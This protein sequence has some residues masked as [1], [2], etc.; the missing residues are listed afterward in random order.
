MNYFTRKDYMADPCHAV[1][2]EADRAAAHRRYYAQFVTP[3][4]LSLV[5]ARIGVDRIKASTDRHFN[6]IPLRLWDQLH[7]ALVQGVANIGAKI[8]GAGFGV[9][10]SDIVCVAKEAAKQIKEGA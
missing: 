9:S 4:V 2:N 1:G 6:D 10:L 8:N 3:Y 7:P 5:R